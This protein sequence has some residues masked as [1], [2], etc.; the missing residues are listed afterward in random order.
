MKKLFLILIS[1]LIIINTNLVYAALTDGLVSYWDW[2]NAG[3]DTQGR[4]NVSVMTNSA[5]ISNSSCLSTKC[6]SLGVAGN[7]WVNTTMNGFVSGNGNRTYGCWVKPVLQKDDSACGYTG[8]FSIGKFASNYRN[9]LTGTSGTASAGTRYFK[10]GTYNGDYTSTT[11]ANVGSWQLFVITVRDVAPNNFSM[12]LN[13]SMF[14]SSTAYTLNTLNDAN[15]IGASFICPNNGIQGYI[16]DC[17]YWNRTLSDAEQLELYNNGAIFNLSKTD[18]VNFNANTTQ[19][20]SYYQNWIYAEVINT[21]SSYSNIT[22]WKDNTLIRN[23]Y[24]TSFPF[25]MNYTGL[26]FGSYVLNATNSLQQFNINLNFSK[27]LFGTTK[28]SNGSFVSAKIV[29]YNQE[30][31]VTYNTTSNSTGVWYFNT[32]T[33][34]NYSIFAFFNSTINAVIRS[35]VSVT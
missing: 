13:G 32:Y 34:G 7:G 21:S 20:G 16:D 22:L 15:Y 33:K 5:Y 9:L 18:Y 14:Y 6:L 1:I 30:L 25:R 17:Y 4:N 31:N 12:F 2:Q 28:F 19:S 24:T 35:F 29:L 23:N 8:Y 11:L 3:N 27:T 10:T 26:D